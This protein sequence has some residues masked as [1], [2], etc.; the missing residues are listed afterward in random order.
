MV[1]VKVKETHPDRFAAIPLK[2]GFFLLCVLCVLC[3]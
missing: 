2:R 1:E 3:G